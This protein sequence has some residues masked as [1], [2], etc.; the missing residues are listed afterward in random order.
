MFPQEHPLHERRPVLVA[1][2]KGATGSTDPREHLCGHA[3]Y[4]RLANLLFNTTEIVQALYPA[5]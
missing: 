5:H 3:A 1:D 2:H 4:T